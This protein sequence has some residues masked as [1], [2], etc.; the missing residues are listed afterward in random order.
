VAGVVDLP[1]G[2]E[3]APILQYGSARPYDLTNSSN[4]LNTGGGT[5][6]GIVVPTNDPKNWFAFAGNNSGAQNCFYGLGGSAASCTIAKYDPLRGDPFF[7]L[8]TR[9]A[10]TIKIRERANVQII[11]EAFNLTNRANYGNNFGR[12]IGSA[13][14]FGHPAGF[15][16]PSSTIIP[17][18]TWGEL[19]ARFTF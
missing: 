5:A 17:R 9:L 18:S 7:Q 11:A 14:R 19:G 10:K 4:T 8:D 15:I 3:V 1:K 2:F 16:A 13:S 12:S 6:V